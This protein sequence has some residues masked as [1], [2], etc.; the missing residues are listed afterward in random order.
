MINCCSPT[1][2]ASAECSATDSG[3]AASKVSG[4][5]KVSLFLS[6]FSSSSSL[7]SRSVPSLG[8]GLSMPPPSWP[9]LCSPLPDRVA[10]V[11]VQIVS[12]PLRWSPLSSFLVVWAP[13]GDT[14]GPSVVFEAVDRWTSRVP[15][16]SPHVHF[17]SDAVYVVETSFVSNVYDHSCLYPNW[18]QRCGIKYIS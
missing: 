12:P 16:W 4:L 17:F 9:V 7:G 1:P 15:T 18:L 10:P 8:E 3:T 5:S 14:H 11:F 2:D 6:V 13:R